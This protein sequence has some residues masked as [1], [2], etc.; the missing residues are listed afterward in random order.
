MGDTSFLVCFGYLRGECVPG[1]S[2]LY[3]R[4][5]YDSWL[6]NT[7]CILSAIGMATHQEQLDCVGGVGCRNGGCVVRRDP[8]VLRR[9]SPILIKEGLHFTNLF[10][11]FE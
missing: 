11:I 7:D 1:S 3:F 4:K 8:K 10:Y 2:V 9:V 5:R 6:P